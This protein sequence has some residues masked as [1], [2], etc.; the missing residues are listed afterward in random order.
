MSPKVNYQAT[1][2]ARED[3]LLAAVG[4]AESLDAVCVFLLP[5]NTAT[6]GVKVTIKDT[7]VISGMGVKVNLTETLF[8]STRR[9][10][11]EPRHFK[12][13]D[14]A[15]RKAMNL[16]GVTELSVVAVGESDSQAEES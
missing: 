9:N 3:V 10:E 15:V 7:L 12:T 4:A 14:V 6:V 1:N 13:L 2:C 5:D 8:L 16:F 11:S